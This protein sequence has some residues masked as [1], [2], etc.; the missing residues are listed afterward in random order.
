MDNQNPIVIVSAARTP[1]GDFLGNL[2]SLHAVNLGS[3]AIK[4]AVERAKIDPSEVNEVIMGCVLS[5]GQGQAPARQAAIY[6][7]LPNHVSCSTINKVCGS[8]MKSV[9]LANDLLSVGDLDIIVAGGMESMSNA[10]YL[11]AKARKGHKAGHAEVID[12]ML[13]D[14]L[15]DAYSGSGMGLLAENAAA[16]Y[17][18]SREAQD[19]FA[20][21]SLQRAQEATK[22]GWFLSDCEIVP[23]TIPQPKGEP[24]TLREDEHPTKVKVERITTLKPSFKQDGT[25]TPANSSAISDG[26]AALVLMRLSE[27]KKRNL[28][29]IA[30]ILG[31]SS[32]AGDPVWYTL[33]PITAIQNLLHKLKWD[34]KTP[35][36]YEINEA[37]AVVTMAAMQELNLAHDKVN[38]LGGACALG[39]PIGASGTRIICTL[40]SALKHQNKTLGVASLCIGGGES[41]AIAIELLK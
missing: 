31:H 26:A 6:A 3:I 4:A 15:E 16:K 24:I 25:I 29:P 27:A 22:N 34:P 7:G 40:L 38:I 18:F 36:L 19:E 10:P 30:K 35:D 32:Y 12:E 37:F 39:H 20:I 17:N 23:T 1:L 9:M 5:A 33:A 13:V 8:G 14:G 2:A 41:T 11:L 28:S 21:A